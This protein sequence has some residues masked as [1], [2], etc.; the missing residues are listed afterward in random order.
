M[1]SFQPKEW[2]LDRTQQSAWIF[3]KNF[4]KL[5]LPFIGYQVLFIWILL[6]LL[7]AYMISSLSWFIETME[8]FSMEDLLYNP[9]AVYFVFLG[10][11]FIFIYLIGL[12]PVILW[13]IKSI[14]QATCNQKV[15]PVENIKWWIKNIF[16]SFKTY[17]YIFS[18]VYLIPA[19]IFIMWGLLYIGT[20]WM[21]NEIFWTIGLIFMMIGFLVFI[22]FAIYRGLKTS[23][24][25]FSAVD[26]ESF[27]KENFTQ[28]IV[29]TKNNWWRIWW[30]FLLIGLIIWLIT[31]FFWALAD[32]LTT[33][34]FNFED[35]IYS[36]KWD[37][38][39][40]EVSNIL[41]KFDLVEEIINSVIK[42]VLTHSANIFIF[43]FT[44]IFMLRLQEEWE[45]NE[46]LELKNLDWEL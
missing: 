26:K 4:L 33:N 13:T 12:I 25:I 41:T 16:E 9:V 38:S 22:V 20:I 34:K 11:F 7:L 15:T 42:A 14:R 32:L 30:N 5:V 21:E 18:Y 46:V 8:I 2:V 43:V 36:S 3:I 1:K 45:N 19:V 23:F 37:L 27:T 24:S 40:S 29:I 17:W 35:L 39:W 44:Y 10:I 28:S 6:S 31:W